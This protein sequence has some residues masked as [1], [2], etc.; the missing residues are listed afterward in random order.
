MDDRGQTAQDFAIGTSVLLVTIIGA[1]VFIQGGALSVYEDSATPI[2]QPQ[3]DRVASYLVENYSVD[4][5]PNVLRYN[6]SSGLDRTLSADTGLSDLTA[7]A[8]VNVSSTR[9]TNPDLNVSIVN[10]SS[11][12]DGRR[13]PARDGNGI[14]L[15]WG[16]SYREQP[17]A[18]ST[19]VVRLANDD[20]GTP[21]CT[22]TCW[23]V[24]R[25]W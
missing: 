13:E 19:R 20:D 7:S 3:A 22:P 2:E 11:L 17:Y 15:A 4:G 23:L 12:E 24:V 5:D 10:S 25:A 1:F 16:E 6:Q 9:R 8:G 21:Q 18:T 14:V